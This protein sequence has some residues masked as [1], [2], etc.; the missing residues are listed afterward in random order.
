MVDALV[1]VEALLRSQVLREALA[2]ARQALLRGDTL[3]QGL[4]PARGFNPLLARLIAVGESSG[5]L[6]DSL[7]E[8]DR[9]VSARLA[10]VV[11]RLA[12]LVEPVVVVV[13]GGVVGFVYIAFF[14]ALFAGAG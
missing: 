11:K 2:N 5:S 10:V 13:V 8:V 1:T 7:R 9:F 4:K 12:A 3:A 14:V 6:E